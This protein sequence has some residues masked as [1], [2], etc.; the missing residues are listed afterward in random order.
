MARNI[1][2]ILDEQIQRWNLEQKFRARAQEPTE[3]RA[4]RVITLSNAIG[5]NGIAVAHKIGEMLHIPVYDREIV[6]HIATT[7]KVRVEAVESL[8]QR[9]LGAVDDYLVNLFR[10]RNFDQSDYMKALTKTI[11]SLWA[12]GSCIF[13]GRG[14]SHIISRRFCLAVRTVA[15]WKHRVRRVQDLTNMTKEQAE[16]E[17]LRIDGDREYFIRRWFKL[18][19]E[20]PLSYDLT[21]NTAGLSTQAAAQLIITAFQ[22]KFV[23]VEDT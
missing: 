19:I 4:Q 12:H 11:T 2:R 3:F 1:S 23:N 14:A 22:Q 8:D 15:P 9:A 20:D 17:V 6:E 5:S 7:E 10:E 18:G 13:I 16:A 21:V